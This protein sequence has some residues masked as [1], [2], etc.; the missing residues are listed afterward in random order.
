MNNRLDF[1][2]L[3]AGVG[4]FNFAITQGGG[5]CIFSSEIDENACKTYQLNHQHTPLGDITLPE[6]QNQ[7]P[8]HNILCAGFPCQPF[9]VAGYRK[10]FLDTRGTLFFE[11]EKIVQKHL[12]EVVFL[13]NVKNLKTHDK[14]NTFATIQ[15][16]LEQL[17]YAVFAEV[18]NTAT[19][20]NIPQNRE[21]I[22]IVCF[23]KDK[24]PNW[25]DFQFPKPIDL[26][27]T[28]HDILASEKQDDGYYYTPENCYFYDDLVSGSLK[29]DTVYQWRRKYIRENKN[30][31]CPT[32][33]ANMGMGGHNVPIIKDAYGF[34]KLTPDECFRF[35][36]YKNFRL[37]EIAKSHLYKQAGNS[38][39]VPLIERI[40]NEIKRVLL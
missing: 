35:Q 8:P 11:I 39:T 12:P 22:F 6:I 2:D 7:I 17:G 20:A 38:V 37:P 40:F 31:L 21:R 32:L 29:K 26:T 10:G 33:T 3:F 13:E 5:N 34:R 28:I 24:V 14:G 4:G 23:H 15:H 18:L 9:S 1:I 30:Q 25:K 16:S 27:K 19:H 36:G